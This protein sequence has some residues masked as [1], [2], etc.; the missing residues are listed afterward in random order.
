MAPFIQVDLDQAK[1]ATTKAK[2][3][4]EATQLRFADLKAH[5]RE[6]ESE[7]EDGSTVAADMEK[8]EH[9]PTEK[10]GEETEE[11][12]LKRLMAELDEDVC[13]SSVPSVDDLNDGGSSQFAIA[14]GE[15]AK[16]GDAATATSVP[17]LQAL[18]AKTQAALA[19]AAQ[20]EV[21]LVA[22]RNEARSL[23]RV[24]RCSAT[25]LEE[26]ATAAAAAVLGADVD[27]T[28]T[29]DTTSDRLLAKEALEACEAHERACGLPGLADAAAD[30]TVA[31][32]QQ[33]NGLGSS[34]T[35]AAP[36]CHPSIGGDDDTLKGA[37]DS[38][39]DG[40]APRA[41]SSIVLQSP[42]PAWLARLLTWSALRAVGKRRRG[43]KVGFKTVDF[44][45]SKNFAAAEAACLSRLAR[46]SGCWPHTLG[47]ATVGAAAAAA[48]ASE[49]AAA[50]AAAS[51][52]AAAAAAASETAAAASS[53]ASETA[54]AAAA[55]SETAAAA[56]SAA[57]ETGAAAAAASETAAAAAAASETAAAAS[58][59]AS[60]TGAAPKA[61]L[62][63]ADA[64]DSAEDGAG[65]SASNSDDNG[66]GAGG[67]DGRV[68]AS[69]AFTP[70]LR[71][72][73]PGKDVG[74]E[75]PASS[76][77]EGKHS[78]GSSN[79]GGRT[80][81]SSSASTDEGPWG[82]GGYA[83]ALEGGVV[84]VHV[85]EWQSWGLFNKG[86]RWSGL[87]E[88]LPHPLCALP[89]PQED[90]DD[91]DESNSRHLEASRSSLSS[92]SSSSTTRK[93]LPG[94]G[95][96]VKQSAVEL[97]ESFG[98]TPAKRLGALKRAQREA[99]KQ[100]AREAKLQKQA[101]AAAAASS[102]SSPS[103]SSGGGKFQW[104]EAASLGGSWPGSASSPSGRLLKK[105][106]V[107][108]TSEVASSS[109]S[110]G[111]VQ[112]RPP[113]PPKLFGVVRGAS[114][115]FTSR[116]G[117]R[118]APFHPSWASTAVAAAVA[119]ATP[120]S[121]AAA[122]SS[123]ASSLSAGLSGWASVDVPPRAAGMHWAWLE[124][125]R[126]DIET[127]LDNPPERPLAASAVT[128]SSG[129]GSTTVAGGAVA[130]KASS[131]GGLVNLD[132]GTTDRDGWMYAPEN[133]DGIALLVGRGG[134]SDC[135]EGQGLVG[136]R[137]S[138]QLRCRRWSRLCVL[139]RVPP[140]APEVLAAA[141][142][143]ALASAAA[144]VATATS[145]GGVGGAEGGGESDDESDDDDD[146]DI[147]TP[148]KA[149]AAVASGHSGEE[150]GSPGIVP[151]PVPL[152]YEWNRI[153]DLRY[154]LAQA[155]HK[156][157]HASNALQSAS[158]H[159][160]QA[161]ADADAASRA[162]AKLQETRTEVTAIMRRVQAADERDAELRSDKKVA[163]HLDAVMNAAAAAAS[164][165]PVSTSDPAVP[166]LPQR[167]SPGS[168][169]GAMPGGGSSDNNLRD[170]LWSNGSANSVGSEESLNNSSHPR[171]RTASG[172]SV[173]QMASGA[174]DAAAA[175]LFAVNAALGRSTR[176]NSANEDNTSG[177]EHGSEAGTA[178]A[179]T[180]TST[181]Q[182][183]A[184]GPSSS[185]FMGTVW[186]RMRPQAKDQKGLSKQ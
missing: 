70:G 41:P 128:S 83:A 109:S 184:P 11:A 78:A 24:A 95:R 5:A 40:A 112:A 152:V 103:G 37:A 162:A 72:P 108:P 61:A 86:G 15:E 82:V 51:E 110:K 18:R 46:E 48:A 182:Q 76:T 150:S 23:L 172:G 160:A 175:A 141:T 16:L 22:A 174:A 8:L 169:K 163:A 186:E 144:A 121:S 91:D 2:A 157:A 101:A 96:A 79:A 156:A 146:A 147:P 54:A 120:S 80:S 90:D 98:P 88:D 7:V 118:A 52:T 127:L 30:A 136:A 133:R 92:S 154:R 3:A 85:L 117:T 60:E 33:H 142:D 161:K 116:D 53:A 71:W 13:E 105:D 111:I 74:N 145:T 31:A 170:R 168:E 159:V 77:A 173:A 67:C 81:S 99:T 135:G 17:S 123:A 176:S 171:D 12:R 183:R 100:A 119:A 97:D 64:P 124:D 14:D 148:T 106:Q 164:A 1:N 36:Y 32:S 149:L 66:A 63:A 69:L 38:A 114:A 179:V 56:S 9:A 131:S 27:T 129:S 185:N 65:S 25:L 113:P 49:T 87:R 165:A 158:W 122:A 20:H 73:Q 57:S 94:G 151:L 132:D 50:A 45:N 102:S 107:L 44:D 89:V 34:G 35:V 19:A 130:G 68:V 140:R 39:T 29:T 84:V 134:R 75:G 62:G 21:G 138:R 55:A 4:T 47:A 104:S 166:S 178:N 126:P 181:E 153:L 42:P 93:L 58:S 177:S 137:P 59:A 10:E 143:A 139:A 6:L 167:S 155:A 28:T 26:R 43:R 115:L 180:V 125:W